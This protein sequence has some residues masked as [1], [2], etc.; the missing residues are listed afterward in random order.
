M[1]GR[2]RVPLSAR[3]S[4]LRGRSGDYY[5]R[6]ADHLPHPFGGRDGDVRRDRSTLPELDC[7]RPG[8]NPVRCSGRHRSPRRPRLRARG[9]QSRRQRMVVEPPDTCQ[10]QCRA[11]RGREGAHGQQQIRRQLLPSQRNLDAVPRGPIRAAGRRWLGCDPAD[12]GLPE[13]V[14]PCF[15][16]PGGGV[17]HQSAR[18]QRRIKTAAEHLRLL[19]GAGRVFRSRGADVWAAARTRLVGEPRRTHRR[20]P[21]PRS[22]R[23]RRRGLPAAR[24]RRVP[25]SGRHAHPWQEHLHLEHTDPTRLPP[26]ALVRTAA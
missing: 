14:R 7:A 10:R 12:A 15:R 9:H 6:P 26:G 2:G 20:H 23:R 4:V 21:V 3:Q 11:R 1:A 18:A 22:D 24:T 16:L 13:V 8:R 5:L 17:S 25:R 19:V